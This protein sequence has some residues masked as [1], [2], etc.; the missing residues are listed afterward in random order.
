M[1]CSECRTNLSGYIEGQHTG[2]MRRSMEEHNNGCHECAA[3]LDGMRNVITGLGNMRRERVSDSFTF[4][5]RRRLVL[6]AQR[7]QS[8]LGRLRESV[9]PTSQ[10]LL[11]AAA[12]TLTTVALLFMFGTGGYGGGSGT[13]RTA[14]A[15]AEP[16]IGAADG[17]SRDVRYVLEHVP[18]D[19]ELIEVSAKRDS[20]SSAAGD[21]AGRSDMT[22]VR[23]D[24]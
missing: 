19:G 10:T 24:F 15:T 9:K 21:T 23:A 4:D 16:T 13:L 8:W 11:A 22:P 3:R 12:G 2:E 20:A 18:L 5:M 17:P 1:T 6:E 14:G 7:E